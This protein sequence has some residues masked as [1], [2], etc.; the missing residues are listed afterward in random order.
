MRIETLKEQARRHEQHEE[1]HEALELYERAIEEQGYDEHADI[2]L[3]NRVGD[4]RIRLGNIG[5]AVDSYV[6]AIDRYLDAELPNNAVAI[7]K[8]VLRSVPTHFSMYL[9]IGQI[10]ASQGFLTDARQ[11][12]LTYA[13]RVQEAGDIEEAFRALIEFADL[14]PDDVE[15][16]LLLAGQLEAHGRGGEAVEQLSQAYRRQAL[17]GEVEQAARLRARILELDPHARVPELEVSGHS[18]PGFESTSLDTSPEEPESELLAEL[19]EI[20]TGAESM[21]GPEE[22]LAWNAEGGLEADGFGAPDPGADVTQGEPASEWESEADSWKGPDDADEATLSW[23]PTDEPSQEDG[24]E[25]PEDAGEWEESLQQLEAV[26]TDFEGEGL[27]RSFGMAVGLGAAGTDGGPEDGG[28]DDWEEE[29]KDDSDLEGPPDLRASDFGEAEDDGR[30]VREYVEGEGAPPHLDVGLAEIQSVEETTLDEQAWT[31]ARAEDELWGDGVTEAAVHVQDSWEDSASGWGRH[32]EGDEEVGP[33]LEDSVEDTEPAQEVTAD[34][35]SGEG[36]PLDWLNH[37]R[38]LLAD[39]DRQGAAR[40]FEAAHRT[41]AAQDDLDRAMGV[42]KELLEIDPD[43]VEHHQTLV[44]YAHESGQPRVLVREFL[45][46]AECLDRVGGI[47]NAEAVY[48]QVLALDP[49]NEA[50]STALGLERESMEAEMARATDEDGFVDLGR[51]I[52]D[53]DGEATTRFFVEAKTPS[54]DENEDFRLMLSQFKEKV[55][56]SLAADDHVAH[57]DLGTAFKEMGLLD[58]AVTEFQKAIRAS[59][60]YLPAYEM[61]G[62]CFLEMGQNDIAVRSL[63]RALNIPTQVEDDLL[64]IYYYL[65]KAHETTGNSTAAREFYEKVFALDINFRDVTDRLRDLREA[66]TQIE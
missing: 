19:G 66:L 60:T 22:E 27:E 34:E 25:G 42:V 61:L 2:S 18:L 15:A 47:A 35:G 7:C 21:E 49:D 39:G 28:S 57:Y 65:G 32:P 14:A 51:L 53:D 64:G 36:G 37:G 50:A 9:K 8:K 45:R 33:D 55:A 6:K 31:D 23:P 17:V 59:H 1:W 11:Q 30:A 56:E 12:F 13:E 29:G 4:L 54:G 38:R 63:E 48:R 58:E 5:A 40:A 24:A 10:R 20:D 52:L 16:R 3:Y 26:A 46:L 44:E 43:S 41:F 62:Q